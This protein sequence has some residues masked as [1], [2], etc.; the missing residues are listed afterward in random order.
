MNS[1]RPLRVLGVKMLNSWSR[2]TSV[3]GG[4]G[5]RRAGR[6]RGPV[7]RAGRQRDVA[8]GDARQR[9]HPDFGG[10][11]LVQRGQ[12]GFD[13][14]RDAH[15]VVVQ[16]RDVLDRPDGHAADLHLVAAHE[17]AGFGEDQ[18]VGGAAVA[19]DHEH[20]HDRHDRGERAGGRDA[21]GPRAGR[22]DRRRQ[23]RRSGRRRAGWDGGR[24]SPYFP[25]VPD[26]AV[27]E[28][29]GS[30]PGSAWRRRRGRAPRR[31]GRRA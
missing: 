22:A 17:L 11:A 6:Q 8:V 31:G 20:Q 27:P 29:R 21:H 4:R 15:V 25:S 5:K 14:D 16:Q 24:H 3:R 30:P 2:S 18:L 19:A 1:C 9:R 28:D 7:V 12:R 23:R 13:V 10:G 26:G